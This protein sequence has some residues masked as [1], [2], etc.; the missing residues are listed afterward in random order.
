MGKYGKKRLELI[1]VRTG[2]SASRASL[3]SLASLAR[4]ARGKIFNSSYLTKSL[5]Y[6]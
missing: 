5:R 4:H 6:F 3:A 1:N 2:W